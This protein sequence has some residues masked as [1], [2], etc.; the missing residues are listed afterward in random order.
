[1]SNRDQV[2]SL[3]KEALAQPS[4]SPSERKRL[5]KALAVYGGDGGDSDDGKKKPDARAARDGYSLEELD[6]QMGLTAPQT[7]ASWNGNKFQLPTLTTA[8]ARA[9]LAEQ[10]GGAR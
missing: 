3:L 2:V 7:E 9:K 8:Q 1:M 4:T 10:R 5:Q 6:R